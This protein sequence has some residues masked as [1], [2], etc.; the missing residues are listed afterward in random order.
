MN[1]QILNKKNSRTARKQ[2]KRSRQ[3]CDSLTE[4]N[5]SKFQNIFE[6]RKTQRIK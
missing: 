6:K 3:T 4:K 2:L 5:L 1:E